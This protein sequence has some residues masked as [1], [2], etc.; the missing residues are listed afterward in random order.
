MT[1]FARAFA[2]LACLALVAGCSSPKSSAADPTA[3]ADASGTATVAP[4]ETPGPV[5]SNSTKPVSMTLKLEGLGD[6]EVG[7]PVPAGSRFALRGGQIPDSECKT[8]SSPDYPGVYAIVEGGTVRRIS[9]GGES[10]VKLV[11]GIG[12]GSVEKDVLAAFPGFKAEP[13]KY[14]AA[15]AKY[16]TQPGNDPRL[17]FEIGEDRLVSVMHVGVQ[18]Q[19]QYVEGCA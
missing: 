11:E 2:P 13:H 1:A 15:P 18:P 5:P 16:L 8:F 19:L 9:V 14:V 4:V 3:S 10:K 17:R 6:I 12:V 7:K